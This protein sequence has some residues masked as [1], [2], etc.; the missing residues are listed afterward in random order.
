MKEIVGS[1]VQ[2][3]RRNDLVSGLG[4][5]QESQGNCRLPAGYGESSNS[6]VHQGH[7]LLQDI[8]GGI[9][10]PA[11]KYCRTPEGRRDSPHVP[12]P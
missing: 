6:A 9:H 2:V 4:N 1:A 3:I 5:I 8:I 10:D 12:Y 7:S 11:Y